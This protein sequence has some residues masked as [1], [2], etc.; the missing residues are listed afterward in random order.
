MSRERLRQAFKVIENRFV[1]LDEPPAQEAIETV[2]GA[3]ENGEIKRCPCQIT[4]QCKNGQEAII[5]FPNSHQFETKRGQVNI[6][7]AGRKKTDQ[8]S[9]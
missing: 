4:V 2:Y 6:L 3:V 5:V 9:S 1:G 7:R 8:A